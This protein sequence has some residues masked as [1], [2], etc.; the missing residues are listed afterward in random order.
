MINRMSSAGLH[1]AAASQI[2]RQQS[3]LAKTQSQVGSGLRIQTPADD[4]VAMMRILS[5]EQNRAGLE[6]YEKNSNILANRLSLGEQA[7]ADATTLLQDVRERTIQANNGALDE[8]ARRSIATD[9]RARAQE[10][11]DIAN[12]RDG[13]GEY[14]FAGFSSETQPFSRTAAGVVYAGDQGVR[15]LQIGADQRVADG[16]S[17]TD[18]FLRIPEGNGAFVTATGV[19]NGTGAIDSGHIVNA[20]AWTSS[21]YSLNFTSGTT[22]EVRDPLA[23]LVASGNYVDG[24]A[25]A[26]NGA[27]VVVTGQPVTGDSFT[28]APATSKDVFRMLDDLARSLETAGPNASG[29]SLVSTAVAAGLTQID[30]AL[31][32]LINTRAV[33]GTRLNTVD[34]A[35]AARDEADEQLQGSIG[36]LRDL[37]YAEAISRMN[38]QLTG[39]QAAQAAYTRIAQLSLFNFL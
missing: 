26:F 5:M 7:L 4:P 2:T 28:V 20:A 12:R 33:V 18:L 19:H 27:E 23:N 15:S 25:I 29:K 38:Q 14:L 11:I 3:L 22:W 37:D 30:Q 34:N 32:H 21:S 13:N 24:S 31:D 10:L 39:L 17:G 35:Q 36:K 16:F 9:I 1:A 8:L 6:Q